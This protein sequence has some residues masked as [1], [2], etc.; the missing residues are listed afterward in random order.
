MDPTL[1]PPRPPSLLDP[2]LLWATAALI[3]TLLLGAVIFAWLD[4]WRKRADRDTYSPA[5]ELTAFRQSYERGELSQQE[6][7]RIRA[8]L[9]PK[10]RQ[11]VNLPPKPAGPAGEGRASGGR[12]AP[13]VEENNRGA[14]G[15]PL[16]GYPGSPD[17]G[18]PEPGPPTAD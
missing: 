15:D 13:G 3:A 10:V 1:P 2:Q 8:R 6:Y 11:Q 12:E 17:L 4:R 18:S 9:A 16:R 7:E 5:D 14:N